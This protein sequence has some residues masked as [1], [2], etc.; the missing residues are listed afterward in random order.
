MENNIVDIVVTI[1][2]PAYLVIAAALAWI[3]RNIGGSVYVIVPVIMMVLAIVVDAIFEL[4]N[5]SP[6]PFQIIGIG[7]VALIITSIVLYLVKKMN[8]SK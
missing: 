4:P 6:Y 3:L 1:L 5:F 7:V 2:N 8:A